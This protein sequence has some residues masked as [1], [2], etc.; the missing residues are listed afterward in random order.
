MNSGGDPHT[1]TNIAEYLS[2]YYASIILKEKTLNHV[3]EL[4]LSELI[5]ITIFKNLKIWGFKSNT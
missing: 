3:I 2:P 1:T 5:N 4:F